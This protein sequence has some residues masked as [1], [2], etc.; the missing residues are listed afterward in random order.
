[1]FKAGLEH[2][3]ITIKRAPNMGQPPDGAW[4]YRVHA[5]KEEDWSGSA[6]TEEEAWLRAT[7]LRDEIHRRL[8][9]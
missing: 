1:M 2:T 3:E 4:Q 5:S 9:V 8:G 6:P 7:M